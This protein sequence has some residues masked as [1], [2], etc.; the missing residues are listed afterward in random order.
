MVFPSNNNR[1]ERV[2]LCHVHFRWFCDFKNVAEIFISVLCRNIHTQNGQTKRLLQKWQMAQ[3]SSGNPQNKQINVYFRHYINKKYV[4][5]Q[6]TNN[7]QLN[8][9]LMTGTGDANTGS[10]KTILSY[11]R[12]GDHL[13]HLECLKLTCCESMNQII[14]EVKPHLQSLR[15]LNAFEMQH[16]CWNSKTNRRVKVSTEV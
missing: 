3:T 9:N 8:D 10:H 1:F 2:L 4:I 6:K 12:H 14:N 15:K 16:M 5:T 13:R 11:V 7:R